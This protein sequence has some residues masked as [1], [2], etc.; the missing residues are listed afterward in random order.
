V[1]QQTRFYICLVENS[2]KMSIANQFFSLS[3][4]STPSNVVLLT[5]DQSIAGNKTFIGAT[6]IT[7]TLTVDDLSTLQDVEVTGSLSVTNA[8]GASIAAEIGSLT[9]DGDINIGRLGSGPRAI[10]IGNNGE[11]NTITIGAETAN[12]TE[13]AGGTVGII[14][15]T[16]TTSVGTYNLT[17]DAASTYT[18]YNNLTT[19]SVAVA[20]DLET[21]IITF[22]SSSTS[23]GGLKFENSTASYNAST[24]RYYEEATFTINL[25]GAVTLNGLTGVISRIGNMVIFTLPGSGDQTAS[26]GTS[27]NAA[28]GTI[29]AR[30]AVTTTAFRLLMVKTGSVQQAAYILLNTDGSFQIFATIGGGNFGGTMAI[31]RQAFCWTV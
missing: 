15:G 6:H 2:K 29:P 13:V 8:G 18:M 26:V 10:Q 30:F 27:W 22:G 11:A 25:T 14:G 28:A 12:L 16:V 17:G 1:R 9:D 7:N 5:T 3:S 19:G 21:G 24:F 4:S 23:T 31:Y 20:P